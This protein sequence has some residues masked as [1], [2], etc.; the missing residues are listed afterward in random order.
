[1]EQTR[2]YLK[3]SSIVV[4]IL[5]GVFMLQVVSELLYGEFKNAAIPDGAPDNILLI[6][7]ISLFLVALL[8][9]LP[10]IYIGIKGLRVAKKPDAS[11]AH[12]VWAVILLVFVSLSLI[13]PVVSFVNDGF[14]RDNISAFLS[15]AVEVSVIFEYIKYAVALRKTTL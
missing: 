9:T 2:K 8:L 7:R 5:A 11:K 10:S 13:E 14:K 4:L 15:T 12:I 1:M 3:L 6:T